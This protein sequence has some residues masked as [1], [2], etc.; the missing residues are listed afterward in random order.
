MHILLLWLTTVRYIKIWYTD[1]QQSSLPGNYSALLVYLITFVCKL[2]FF[3]RQRTQPFYQPLPRLTEAEMVVIRNNKH[4]LYNAMWSMD[5]QTLNG[6]KGNLQRVAGLQQYM[7]CAQY[8]FWHISVFRFNMHELV[9]SVSRALLPE[10][11]VIWF[12]LISADSVKCR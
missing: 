10:I 6:L 2:F 1:L 7:L 5:S 11:N 4:K 12:D 8:A 3:Q 9:R